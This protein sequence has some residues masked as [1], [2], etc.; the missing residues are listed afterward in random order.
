M[1]LVVSGMPGSVKGLWKRYVI[2]WKAVGD[3]MASGVEMWEA[4]RDGMVD[5]AEIT[6]RWETRKQAT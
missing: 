1:Q 4:I 6:L 5:A 3:E 2:L